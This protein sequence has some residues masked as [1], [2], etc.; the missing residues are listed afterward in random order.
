VVCS[1]AALIPNVAQDGSC[2]VHVAHSLRQPVSSKRRSRACLADTRLRFE[3]VTGPL[4]LASGASFG[5]LLEPSFVPRF[6]PRL[7]SRELPSFVP[8]FVPRF[9]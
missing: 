7:V 6:V 2:F 8:R 1:V 4:P 9:V 5:P 3:R